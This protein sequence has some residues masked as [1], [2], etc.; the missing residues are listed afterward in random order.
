MNPFRHASQDFQRLNPGLFAGTASVVVARLPHA[1]TQHPLPSPLVGAHSR[2]ERGKAG[3][4][5]RAYVRFTLCRCRLLDADNAVASV[6]FIL[7]ALVAERLLPGDG[8]GQITLAV[9]QVRVRT[10]ADEG[11]RIII[12]PAGG[13]RMS[14]PPRPPASN[15]FRNWAKG[16]V[17]TAYRITR[18][19]PK[20][21]VSL[22]KHENQKTNLLE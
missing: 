5:P 8:P 12:T 3:R 13:S 1:I 6:K 14:P 19:R 17:A 9:E 20:S 22:P 10:R 18:P 2:Q 21:L 16:V 11:T 15:I 7:D 4:P